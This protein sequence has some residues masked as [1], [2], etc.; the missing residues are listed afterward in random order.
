MNMMF[1]EKNAAKV[2]IS[3]EPNLRNKLKIPAKIC[4]N[5]QNRQGASAKSKYNVCQY[6]DSSDALIR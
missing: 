4:N 5:S 1:K 3:F 6:S 2:G